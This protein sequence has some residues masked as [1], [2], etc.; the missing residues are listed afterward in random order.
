MQYTIRNVSEALDA[1]LR[2]RASEERRSLN[3]LVLRLL[4]QALGL[5]I[6][7]TR[8]R[9][10]GDVAGSWQHDPSFDQALADQDSIDPDLWK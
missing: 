7:A 1:R 5:S 4:T 10:L 9:D 8:R 2:E 3:D 6:E